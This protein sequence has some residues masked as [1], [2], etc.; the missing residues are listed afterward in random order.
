[1]NDQ[2]WV[3][4]RISYRIIKVPVCLSIYLPILTTVFAASWEL[5][6]LEQLPSVEEMTKMF[7]SSGCP[8]EH[9]GNRTSSCW[10]L[11]DLFLRNRCPLTTTDANV[12]KLPQKHFTNIQYFLINKLNSVNKVNLSKRK[13]KSNQNFPNVRPFDLLKNNENISAEGN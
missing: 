11:I 8:I 4:S 6:L 7:W 9:V 5:K 13:K 12:N 3:H 1:M 2:Q 10:K